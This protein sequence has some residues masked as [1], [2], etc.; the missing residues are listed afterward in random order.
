[1]SCGCFHGVLACICACRTSVWGCVA[2][3]HELHVSGPQPLN[4]ENQSSGC[5]GESS[6]TLVGRLVEGEVHTVTAWSWVGVGSDVE[7][8]IIFLACAQV[9]QLLEEP[10][11]E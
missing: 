4:W 3:A 7:F 6:A 11:Q 1:M 5:R 9:L 10:R 2:G 8:L